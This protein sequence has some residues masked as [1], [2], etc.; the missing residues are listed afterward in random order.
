ML[1]NIHRVSKIDAGGI[2]LG[3]ISDVVDGR[4]KETSYVDHLIS[5][6]NIFAIY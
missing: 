5:C 4:N 6:L 2:S 1:W 3:I